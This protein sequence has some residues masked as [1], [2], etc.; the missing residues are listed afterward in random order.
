MLAASDNAAAA[1]RFV[2]YLLGR[3]AQAYFAQ[4]T[5]EYP[6][7]E[8]AAPPAGA[9][10]LAE[11]ATPEIDL[12]DLDSLARDVWKKFQPDHVPAYMQRT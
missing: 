9:P 3:D 6:L 5:F 11:L 10:P 4:E 12:S 1:Q 8:G 7:V 2:D